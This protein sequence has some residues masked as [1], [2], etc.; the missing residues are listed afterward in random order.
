MRF[1]PYF[2]DIAS[3]M[4]VFFYELQNP[5]LPALLII[6]VIIA[7]AVVLIRKTV[8]KNKK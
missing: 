5:S 4:E 6:A 7:A 2:M 8:K 3:P 1:L